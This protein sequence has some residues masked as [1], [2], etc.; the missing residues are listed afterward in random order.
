ME[1]PLKTA[2]NTNPITIGTRTSLQVDSTT[3]LHSKKF[4]WCSSQFCLFQS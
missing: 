1:N 2:D 4:P 3:S